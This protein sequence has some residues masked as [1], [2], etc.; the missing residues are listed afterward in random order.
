M[1][2]CPHRG[3]NEVSGAI[4]RCPFLHAVKNFQGEECAAR[5][6]VNPFANIQ[7]SH[8][9]P[10]LPEDP[11]GSVAA[12]FRLFHGKGGPVPIKETAVADPPRQSR[13]PMRNHS[14]STVDQFVAAQQAPEPEFAAP[15]A[16][17]MM[18]SISLSGFRFLVSRPSISRQS[19]MRKPLYHFMS[20][21][22]FLLISNF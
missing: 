11:A 14:A 22:L 1:A 2:V 4:A 3:T 17:P 9:M 16:L 18:A 20:L 6:A 12:V 8:S 5:L 10:V 15:V 7:D 19:P 21:L 13:C